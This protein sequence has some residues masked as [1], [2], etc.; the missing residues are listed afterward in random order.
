MNNP[1]ELTETCMIC[2]RVRWGEY[3]YLGKG[4]WRHAECY[5][6]SPAW[7]EYYLSLPK[8]KRTD[9]GNFLLMNAM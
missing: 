4:T 9:A 8:E 7:V 2:N 1:T 5:P 6:G 3:Q